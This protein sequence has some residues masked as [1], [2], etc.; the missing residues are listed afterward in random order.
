MNQNNDMD[1]LLLI[2]NARS[3]IK[4][5]VSLA[6]LKELVEIQCDVDEIAESLSMSGF[7][8]EE[9]RDLKILFRN[10]LFW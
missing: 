1:Y 4:M 2:E 3:K 7:E 9:I 6:W 10:I 5:K 8:V